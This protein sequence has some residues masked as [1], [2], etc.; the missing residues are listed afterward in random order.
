MTCEDCYFHQAALCALQLDAICPTFRHHAEA[1]L[2][3]RQ[4]P[5]IP[6]QLLPMRERLVAQHRAA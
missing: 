1:L 6:R 3:P 2:A 5:L 4:A